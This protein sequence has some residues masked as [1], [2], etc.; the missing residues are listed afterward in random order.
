MPPKGLDTRNHQ[1]TNYRKDFRRKFGETA[2][3]SAALCEL[4]YPEGVIKGKSAQYKCDMSGKWQK[5][6]VGKCG[7]WEW[8]GRQGG[9]G[10]LQG[11]CT[12]IGPWGFDDRAPRTPPRLCPSARMAVYIAAVY[13]QLQSATCLPVACCSLIH[14]PPRI[15]AGEYKL[16]EDS[17]IRPR[18]QAEKINYWPFCGAF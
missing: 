13:G 5:Q 2:G 1:R 11:L 6:K 8:R 10:G 18:S 16:W 14:G 7:K 9:F 12:E 17:F 3:R 4:Y 15:V